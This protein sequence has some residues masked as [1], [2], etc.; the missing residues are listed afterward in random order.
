NEFDFAGQQTDPT[1]L[2]Y[3]RARYMD[4]ETGVFLSREP[5]AARIGWLGNP[6]GYAGASPAQMVDPT[7]FA[8]VDSDTGGAGCCA[9]DE[10][11]KFGGISGVIKDAADGAVAVAS[12]TGAAIDAAADAGAAAVSTGVD[13]VQRI[14]DYLVGLLPTLEELNAVIERYGNVG[15]YVGRWIANNAGRLGASLDG[16]LRDVTCSMAMGA[17]MGL[18]NAPGGAMVGALLSYA[19]QNP[20]QATL[21]CTAGAVG[22]GGIATALIPGL[23][24]AGGAAVGCVAAVA[25]VAIDDWWASVE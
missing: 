1:G 15:E 21:A 23:G 7:G 3:L 25:I 4:P 12:A 24:T 5:L 2:Q 16:C 14:S 9:S 20:R 13:T 22:G 18:P 8:L 10:G 11:D 19:Y 17:A 6:F